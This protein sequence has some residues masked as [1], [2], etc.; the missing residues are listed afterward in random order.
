MDAWM[1]RWKEEGTMAVAVGGGGFLCRSVVVE[2]EEK[3]H[4]GADAG[5]PVRI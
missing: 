3:V 5:T 2:K 1:W 4:E